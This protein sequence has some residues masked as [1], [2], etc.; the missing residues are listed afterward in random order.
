MFDNGSFLRRRKRFKRLNHHHHHHH[1]S[2]CFHHGPMVSSTG[3]PPPPSFPPMPFPFVPTSSSIKRCFPLLPPPLPILPPP[4]PT[5]PIIHHNQKS[6]TSFTIDNLIG[7]TKTSSST[8]T[9]VNSVLTI[10]NRETFRV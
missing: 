5:I 10:T 4:P 9:N 1:H 8:T 6:K 3:A 2:A 7:N